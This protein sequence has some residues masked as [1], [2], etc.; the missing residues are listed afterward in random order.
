MTNLEIKSN[1]E[2]GFRDY[3]KSLEHLGRNAFLFLENCELSSQFDDYNI[4]DIDLDKTKE[5]DL[6]AFKLELIGDND[7]TFLMNCDINILIFKYLYYNGA[8]GR[9]INLETLLNKHNIVYKNVYKIY[10]VLDP[11]DYTYQILVNIKE[12]EELKGEPLHDYSMEDYLTHL[13][14]Y[15][16]IFGDINI[17]FN[18]INYKNVECFFKYSFNYADINEEGCELSFIKDNIIDTINDNLENYKLTE[19]EVNAVLEVFKQIDDT[20]VRD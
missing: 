11:C 10:E 5:S 16:P 4:V 7:K 12:Y 3:F 6:K 18:Y 17:S 2:W 19:K 9:L 15:T 1:L 8:G 13:L 14:K 20:D